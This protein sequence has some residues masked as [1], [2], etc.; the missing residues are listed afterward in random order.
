VVFAVAGWCCGTAC[1]V[2]P[3]VANGEA[4]AAGKILEASGVRGGLIVHLGCGDGKLTAALRAGDSYLVHGLDCQA[5]Q[6]DSAREYLT[7]QG[8]Y[9][10]VSVDRW[11]G[12]RLP[13]I[14]NAV[15]LLVVSD[16]LSVDTEEVRRVLAPG[17]VAY[18]LQPSSFI[19]HPFRTTE[20][21]TGPICRNGPEGASHKLDLSPF[22]SVKLDLS[23]FRSVKPRPKEIDE[24]TH[25]LHDASNNAV[26]QDTVIGPPRRLQW[27][28]GPRWSRHHDHMAS[29]SA[30]VS[31]GGRLFYIFDEGPTASILLPSKWTLV[32]RD[33]FSGVILWKQPLASWHPH[34]WKLKSGPAQLPRRLVAV[35][36]R[37]YVTLALDGPL[38]ALDAATGRTV[39][40]YEGTTATEEIVCS[41]GVLFLLV[42]ENPIRYPT[43][44]KDLRYDWPEGPRAIVA[45]RAASG[46]VLWRHPCPWVAT[47]TLTADR[48]HVYFHDG[49]RIVC[50]DRQRGAPR[51]TSEPVDRQ[52]PL[53]SC[54]APTLVAYDNVVLFCGGENY[55]PHRGA[56]D[57]LLA[58]SADDGHVLW[59]AEHP[60]SG[61]Q[62]PEDILVVGGLVWTAPLTS[63]SDSGVFTGRDPRTGAV[64]AQFAPDDP[65]HMPH[66]RC[67]R[68]KATENYLLAGRT[69]IECVD[70]RSEHWIPQHWVRGGCLYGIL[71]ANGLIYTPPHD[72]ACYVEAKLF[73]FNALAPEKKS[74][75]QRVEESKSQ[76]AQGPTSDDRLE[77][78]PA[79]EIS[80]L[81]SQ[82]QNPAD[83][84]AYRHDAERSGCASTTVPTELRRL[85]QADL[86]GRPTSLTVGEGKVFAAV[87]NAHTV[88]AL[89]RV[90]GRVAWQRTVGGRVDSPPTVWQGRVLFGAKDGCVYCLRAQDGALLWRFRAAPEDQ[91]LVADEQV[92][93]VWPVS[94]SVL[95]H[96]G[97]AWCVAGRSMYLDGGLR[98]VRLDAATGRMLSETV[99]DDRDPATGESL[100]ANIR[101]PNLPVAL[102]D[103]LSCDGRYVYMRS[104]RFDLQGQRTE[105]V[106]PRN[107]AD[108]QGSGA[109]LFSP[110]GFLDDSWWHRSYWIFGKT[111]LAGAGGWPLAG[112]RAPAGRILAFDDERVFGFGRR[113]QHFRWTTPLEYHLFATTR[114]PA[115]VNLADGRPA[116]KV[117]VL[118]PPGPAKAAKAAQAGA[119]Q[120]ARFACQWSKA[121]PLQVRALVIAG[122]TLFLAGPPDVLDE[123]AA[124]PQYDDAQQARAA[125]QAAAL[126]GR[127]GTLLLAVSAA[128]GTLQAAY[129]LDSLPVFD[130]LVAAHERL[131][132][133]T[134]D[135]RVACFGS[136]AGAALEPAPGLELRDTPAPGASAGGRATAR[137]QPTPAHP[138][139]AL[140][141]QVEVAACDLGY[142]LR[143]GSGTVG[144]ALRKLPE[145]LAKQ[146]T[147]KVR[148]RMLPN[149]DSVP[150]PANGY[151]VFGDAADDEH[152]V[153]CGLRSRA[154]RCMIVQGP[155]L[156][157]KSHEQPLE[158]KV[159]QIL[160]L[161]VTV[162]LEAQKATLTLGD[163][164]VEA[165]LDRRLEKVSYVGYAV[166]SVASEFSAIEIEGR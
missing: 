55:V 159:N 20:K 21:G 63:G 50:L 35:D 76:E 15:N 71:P 136:G 84:L 37:V 53:T 101:W 92:E 61:Y 148:L 128:D 154:K 117:E 74:K 156:K 93:S 22:R 70:F 6:V 36:D 100:Q 3:A 68:A 166:H 163:Q 95:V 79:Y 88:S 45:V 158:P 147:L 32:A 83:W 149:D 9:G 33:A 60:R 89:D 49:Q 116:A 24:W 46:E 99:L 8:L 39:C 72:C 138:D 134:A 10:P 64:K 152:L 86:G 161:T 62:S 19:P 14:D 146:A 90:T 155:L 23:P 114:A 85:W 82:I 66:H 16:P 56:D 151:L 75:S 7:S 150:P 54:Y 34:L 160:D 44:P 41:D 139:F 130:G 127:Q 125:E 145:P 81:K 118:Y 11:N 1:S 67:H 98:L 132:L 17:G 108:Q 52:R 157:G 165:P 87:T 29:T 80:N 25:Y 30:M 57:K 2:E 120:N 65:K 94:G 141:E 144:F 73:G 18:S 51:W 143:T 162:D 123:D 77:K 12:S 69:G 135:G 109:H 102:P 13:Y 47:L 142:R 91:R 113:A 105:V 115:I 164:R 112:Q 38:T 133:A 107:A 110:T 129:R 31:A 111:F 104:Q 48:R 131:F 126:D 103:L 137:F 124:W 27:T 78:G 106:A 28:G 119:V 121:A 153:K 5:A 97:V 43:N 4:Q 42:N 26:A 122:G 58:L 140:V 40:T 59:Q 96:A